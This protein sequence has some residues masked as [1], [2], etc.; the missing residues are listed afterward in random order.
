MSNKVF[1][2]NNGIFDIR[3]MLTF[4]L[5]AKQDD[6]AIGFFGTGFKYAIAIILRHHGSIKIT[7]RGDD[8]YFYCYEFVT[9]REDFRGQDRDFVFIKD[10]TT[11]DHIAANFTTHMG[12]NWQPWMA[13]RELYCNCID[14]KG[15]VSESYQDGF[16]TVIEVDCMEIL[17]TLA[18]KDSYILDKDLVPVFETSEIQVF[19]KSLPYIFYKGVAVYQA[20]TKF[21][22]NIKSHIQLT[23][24]RTV[25]EPWYCKYYIQRAMQLLNVPSMIEAIMRTDCFENKAGFDSDYS[26]SDIF[27][28]TLDK[29]SKTEKGITESA[30][31]LLQKHIIK[32]RSFE[33]FVLTKVQ[34]KMVSRAKT[35]L[36]KMDIN[37][38]DFR[39]NFVVGLG[40]GVMGRALDGEIYISEMAFQLGTKQLSGTLMEEWVHLKTGCADFDRTMQN[41][42]FDRI[43][44]LGENING[45]PI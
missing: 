6:S 12:I 30:R 16:D 17:K 1:F 25:K 33:P 35:F 45:E 8:G 23:E 31:F 40:E 19:D 32:N 42:L 4:G 43:I 41:W 21:G 39:I 5:S 10:H 3:G 7:T 14:E 26:C 2:M 20:D 28:E 18:E 34:Q 13:F 22:Y 37:V 38:D 29:L 44:T 36:S 15:T 11:G 9:K 27:I 24:D